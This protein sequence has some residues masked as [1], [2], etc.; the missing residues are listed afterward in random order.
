MV[1]ILIFGSSTTYGKCDPN[2]GWAQR[3]RK[4][5]DENAENIDSNSI[6]NLG[7]SGDTTEEL[8]RR[9]EFETKQRM[10]EGEEPIFIF[11]IGINDSQFL[12]DKQDTRVAPEKFRANL[13]NL[14]Q[15]ARNFSPKI[16]F[17]GFQPVDESRTDPW[18]PG[19]SYKM[20]YVEK[21]DE[22]VKEVCTETN[23]HFVDIL[24]I[25]KRNDYKRLLYDGVHLNSEGH[26]KVFEL[27]RNFLSEHKFI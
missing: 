5:I 12:H 3:L 6:F 25:L 10:K 16:I 14:L 20:K 27:V 24:P 17:V 19:E 11:L 1:E 15:M 4:Y 7:I 18:R 21:Y 26:Q 8:L 22:I 23:T 2:G 9:F 13:R